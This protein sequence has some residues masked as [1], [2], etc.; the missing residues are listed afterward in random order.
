MFIIT[1]IRLIVLDYAKYSRQALKTND[2]EII[3]TY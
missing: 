2:A 3:D 1:K